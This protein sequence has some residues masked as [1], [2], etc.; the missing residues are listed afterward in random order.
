MRILSVNIG[1]ERTLQNGRNLE[2]TGIY[3][4]ATVQ[5]VEVKTLGLKDDFIFSSKHHGG[6]DQAVYIYGSLDY[7]WWSKELDH[8]LGPGTFGENLTISDL[9]SAVFAVGDRLHVGQVVL[10]VTSPRIPCG[11]LAARMG[12]P[13]F[14]KRYRQAERPDLYCRVIQQGVL[15]AGDYVALTNFVGDRLSILE[16]FR[17]YYEK[18]KSKTLIERYLQAPVAIRVRTELEQELKRF[19]E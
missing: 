13:L 12:D 6:P 19:L 10:E 16:V 3:K 4:I 14:V 15:Q 7:D 2:T 5:P 1:Q 17:G 18:D 9:E 8:K 11:T